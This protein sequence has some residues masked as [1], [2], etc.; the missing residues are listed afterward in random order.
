MINN[1]QINIVGRGKLRTKITDPGAIFAL[2]RVL[3]LR[4]V[5]GEMFP[6]IGV[7]CFSDVSDMST[8]SGKQNVFPYV[9]H[10]TDL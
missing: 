6:V 10:I 8:K 5:S 1:R 4:E 9:S 3:K 2:I 7:F